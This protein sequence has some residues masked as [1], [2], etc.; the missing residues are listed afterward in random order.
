MADDV[1]H[2]LEDLHVVVIVLASLYWEMTIY[3]LFFRLNFL[4]LTC[5]EVLNKI[6]SLL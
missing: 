5:I 3:F 1:Y 4:L 2:Q 6:L